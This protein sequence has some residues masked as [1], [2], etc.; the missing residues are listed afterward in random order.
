MSNGQLRQTVPFLLQITMIKN[1]ALRGEVVLVVSKK[2]KVRITS[3]M[4][5]GVIAFYRPKEGIS[6]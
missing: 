1:E 2:V 3:E 6:T 4:I 5:A